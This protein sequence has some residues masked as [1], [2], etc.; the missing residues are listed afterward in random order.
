M[1]SRDANRVGAAEFMITLYGQSRSRA[2]RSLWALEELG[3]GY[4]QVPIAPYTQSR[5]PEYLRI[6]PNG[7]IPALDDDGLIV[8]E[9]LAI[10]LYLAS[11]YGHAPLWPVTLEQRAALYQWSFW[12]TTEIEPNFVAM[13]RADR[14]MISREEGTSAHAALAC[15]L[16]VLSHH[17]S[18]NQYL[19]GEEFSVA[20]LNVASSISEPHEAGFVA[21][22][23]DYDLQ[24]YPGLARWLREC[25]DRPANYRVRKLP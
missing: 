18:S 9:S 10:N 4:R 3:I 12:V 21:G 16:A 22:R 14:G 25:S 23:K 6:N 7:H 13:A 17:L 15:A 20:D 11:K 5:T 2:S 24:P 8:W 1:A 19:L